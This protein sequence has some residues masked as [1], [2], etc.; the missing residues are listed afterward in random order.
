M[1]SESTTK[2]GHGQETNV[3]VASKSGKRSGSGNKNVAPSECRHK[4]NV[5]EQDLAIAKALHKFNANKSTIC[6]F[7][8]AMCHRLLWRTAVVQ[9]PDDDALADDFANELTDIRQ[10]GKRWLCK[11]CKGHMK[12]GNMSPQAV[13]N[14]LSLV[15]VEHLEPLNDL[16]CHLIAPT[17]PFMKIVN[18]PKNSQKG[19]HGPVVCVPSN[20]AKVRA[21]LPSPV[22]DES[23]IKVKLKRK[24]EYNGHYLFRQVSPRKI[25][26]WL[27]YL[28]DNHPSYTGQ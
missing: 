15:H 14:S 11:T 9:L 4:P 19:I 28:K 20:I 13:A 7:P 24:L 2:T 26:H 17:I 8:C 22:N 18:L 27:S 5:K 1:R 23:I 16:E 3:K 21:V 10:Y 12:K 6:E 25:D